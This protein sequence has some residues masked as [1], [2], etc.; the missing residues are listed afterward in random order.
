MNCSVSP[1]ATLGLAGV[2]AI[3]ASAA[4]VTVSVSVGLVTFP[5]VA[6]IFVVP[7]ASVGQ[8]LPL[9]VATDGSP[10]PSD[11][12]RQVLRRVVGVVPVAVNCSVSPLATLGSP[13][14]RR[15][16]P[17][18]RCVTVSVSL[19]LVTFPK[20]AVMFVVPAAERSWPDPAA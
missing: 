17:G 16:I 7:I 8:A 5:K 4:V 11:L 6:V 20:V 3:D 10:T 2:T 19:G 18:R 9:I 12:A 14:S 15:S 1:L 13:E